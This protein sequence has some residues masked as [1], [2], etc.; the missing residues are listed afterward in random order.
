[1]RGIYAF[2][3]YLFIV[4]ALMCFSMGMVFAGIISVAIGIIGLMANNE[5]D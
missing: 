1:M 2:L 4:N 3:P 5:D